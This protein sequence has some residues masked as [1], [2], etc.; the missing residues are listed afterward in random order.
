MIAGLAIFQALMLLNAIIALFRYPAAA[1]QRD[2]W[3]RCLIRPACW[4]STFPVGEHVTRKIGGL[5]FNI[6]TIW[7]TA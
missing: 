7:T 5:T 1:G 2:W 6:D 3:R 4:R